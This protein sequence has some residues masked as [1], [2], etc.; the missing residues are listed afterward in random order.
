MV[1]A[2]EVTSNRAAARR[3]RR[4]AILALPERDAQRPGTVGNARIHTSEYRE[5]D[6]EHGMQM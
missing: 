4:R 2:Q 6:P 3:A 5:R 1:I